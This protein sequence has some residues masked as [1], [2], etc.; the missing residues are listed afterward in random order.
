M[1]PL[2][3]VLLSARRT[4]FGTFG[5]ALKDLSATDLGVHA[6]RAA[7]EAAGVAPADVGH[8][9]MGNVAQTSADAIYL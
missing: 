2:D 9:I 6:A 8:V 7:I 5:G 4:P 1:T 3:V